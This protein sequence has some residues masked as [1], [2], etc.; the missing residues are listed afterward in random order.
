MQ[1]WHSNVN[2][3]FCV[4]EC[5]GANALGKLIRRSAG[6]EQRTLPVSAYQ[7]VTQLKKK[8]DQKMLA[9]GE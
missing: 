2:L 6:S 4:E 9:L 3:T 8:A 1:L 5:G 7:N